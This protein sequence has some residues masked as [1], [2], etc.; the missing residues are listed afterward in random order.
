[1]T[2][3]NPAAAR[4]PRADGKGR[5][6][7]RYN[8]KEAITAYCFLLPLLV[9]VVLFFIIPIVQTLGYAFTKYKG[10]GTPEWIGINN[11]VKLFTRDKK[12]GYEL[13]NTFTFV[14]GTIPITLAISLVLAS[15]L[16]Q[17]VRG[18]SFFRTVLFLP[19]V[20]MT[21]VVAMV[22]QWLLNAEYGIVNVALKSLIGISPRWFSDTKL[23]MFSMC[24]IAVWQGC[25][26]CIVI[27]LAGL[28]NI[29]PTYYEAARIDG[30]SSVQQFFK[31][32]IPLL[33][34][35]LFF[36]LITRMIAA[37]NQFDLV[38]MI[39]STPGP[40]Q[41]S[42]RTLVLGIYQSGFSDFAMGYACAKA[43]ILFGIVM[44]VTF[45]QMLGEKYWVN[46]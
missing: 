19:N 18:R 38:Y 27:L 42:L 32:T 34:P 33:T 23:T 2:T 46:Y 11:F 4:P 26:Y 12:F 15:L 5:H 20:T 36:L 37:F 16:N 9:G 28:Q 43:T 22:W 3:V 21:V 29:S 13:R 44:I 1:M 31:I 25:G 14:L 30:A 24:L 40:V 39:A 6:I 35:T 45:L 41:N 10:M 7:H 17:R 8:R